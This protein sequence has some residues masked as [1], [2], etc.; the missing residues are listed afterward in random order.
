MSTSAA[1]AHGV[2]S[3]KPPY[4]YMRSKNSCE[5]RLVDGQALERVE[6]AFHRPGRRVAP[7]AGQH[8]A[9]ARDRP[10]G[11]QVGPQQ[12]DDQGR[13]DL[14]VEG[15]VVQ[16]V[17]G[18]DLLERGAA[19]HLPPQELLGLGDLDDLLGAAVLERVGDDALRARRAAAPSPSP[20]RECAGAG[21]GGR[22]PRWDLAASR[23]RRRPPRGPAARC[24]CASACPPRSCRRPRSRSRSRSATCARCRGPSPP[25]PSA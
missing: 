5:R 16:Q 12:L 22:R 17:G 3:R 14:E 25:A 11:Q 19:V 24:A 9:Q 8:R 7:V 18:R 15:A 6:R 1:T 20:R 4:R 21:C 13:D 10:H 2:K 23:S